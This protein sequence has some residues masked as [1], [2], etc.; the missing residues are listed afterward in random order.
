MEKLSIED[1]NKL[2]EN[3]ILLANKI[4]YLKKKTLPKH[5]DI[6]DLK[7]A[8]YFGLVDASRKFDKNKHDNFYV[9]AKIRITGEIKDF[10]RKSYKDKIVTNL[11]SEHYD[12]FYFDFNDTLHN[13]ERLISSL[14]DN[15]KKVL[16][17]YYYNN[18]SVS[19]I[20]RKMNLS[21]GRI[22]QILKKSVTILKKKLLKE[23]VFI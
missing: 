20:S 14:K 19:E 16:T 18:L 11:E 12:L 2:V 9:Y 3:Y 13:F 17:Y 1:R 4:A 10:I 22:S 5:I 6:E 15:Y 8:A 21:K 7:S 23:E